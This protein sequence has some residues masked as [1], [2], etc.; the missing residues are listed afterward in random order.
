VRIAF[1]ALLLLL[2][3]CATAPTEPTALAL[4]G[5]GKSLEQFNADELECRKL[6]SARPETTGSWSEQQRRY[7]FAYIQCMYAKGHRVPVPGQLTGAPAGNPPPP[8]S[9]SPPPPPPGQSEP[10]PR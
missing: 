2:G 4:P 1:L 9:G 6:A 10:A 5:T 7:D 3:A 8:P